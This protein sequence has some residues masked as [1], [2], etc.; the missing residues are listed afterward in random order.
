[1]NYLQNNPRLLLVRAVYIITVQC[2][3]LQLAMHVVQIADLM[4]RMDTVGKQFWYKM[5]P[6][7]DHSFRL[8]VFLVE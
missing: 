6:V 7:A 4:Q 1:M 5:T 8:E 3:F 2:C